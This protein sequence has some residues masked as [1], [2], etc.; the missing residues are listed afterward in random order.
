MHVCTCLTTVASSC[1]MVLS[2]FCTQGTRFGTS[3]LVLV[4]AADRAECLSLCT[5]ALPKQSMCVDGDGKGHAA[6]LQSSADSAAI[7]AGMRT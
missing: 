4:T 6:A 5:N 7:L 3:K 1:R 2:D